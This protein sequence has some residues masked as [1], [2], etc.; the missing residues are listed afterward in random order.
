MES[1]SDVIPERAP[2]KSLLR[3][4]EAT[5][6]PD[7]PRWSRAL[8]RGRVPLAV[9]GFGL[10]VAA[11]F[12][13]IAHY[14]VNTIYAD[15]W[16]NISLVGHPLSF[17]AL[18]TQHAEHRML[19][20]NLIV[21]LLAHTTH[22]NFVVEEYLNALILCGAIG[23]FVGA[24]RRTHRSTPWLFYCPVAFLLLSLVQA[25]STL[26]GF[27]LAWYLAIGM[28]A[29][30]LFL[31]DAADLTMPAFIGACA[32]AVIGSVSAFEG[33]FIWPIGLLVL[34]RRRAS[35]HRMLAWVV[36]A[37]V[38]G[39]AYFHN[40]RF[41]SNPYWYSHP[42][43]TLKFFFLAVGDVVGAQLGNRH[44][45]NVAVLA[46]GVVIA[47]IAG[48][49]IV[50]YGIRRGETG[51]SSIGVAL[52]CFGLLFAA[53]FAVGRV[54]GGFSIAGESQYTT[55]DLMILVGC[56]MALLHPSA[57]RANAG[58]ARWRRPTLAVL[59]WVVCGVA[60]LQVAFGTIN[61]ITTASDSK[62]YLTTISDITANIDRAPVSLVDKEVLQTPAWIRRMAHIAERD[63]LSLFSTGAVVTYRKIGLFPALSAVQAQILVPATGATVSGHAVLDAVATADVPLS[64]VTFD[65]TGASGHYAVA[66]TARPTVAGWVT[67][68]DTT[69]VA[70]GT[71]RVRCEGFVAGRPPGY[72][73][74]IIITVKNP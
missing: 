9:L 29:A 67:R 21:V 14:G 58:P 40:Y 19:V 46:L 28:F 65:I 5:S 35:R 33:L 10:P 13:L 50:D 73:P 22:L 20:P 31:L 42:L 36:V 15:Q 37:L 49:V 4:D 38:T 59:R 41:Q 24:D 27:Q 45:G 60:L 34:Y 68:W 25:S 47:V 17:S 53:S 71:Y 72:S 43:Q 18:W 54:D 66:R 64:R 3:R 32:V 12:W 8:G 61:G 11:Y 30:A 2:T 55:F 62:N 44:S 69:N 16:Y 57:G 26:F 7:Q 63:H 52:V 51:G 48:W 39:A 56:Y 70:N 1:A 23:L 6:G 74:T